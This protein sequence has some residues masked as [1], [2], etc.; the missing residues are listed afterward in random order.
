MEMMSELPDPFARVPEMAAR[1]GVE[2]VAP[3]AP[4]PSMALMMKDGSQYDFFALIAAFLDRMDA[5][6]DKAEVMKEPQRGFV[7]H[8]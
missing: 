6:L 5:A 7:E 8:C 3:G 4:T 1:L 2:P